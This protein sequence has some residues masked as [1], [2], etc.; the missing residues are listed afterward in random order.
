MPEPLLLLLTSTTVSTIT[1]GV[2]T[3]RYFW[4]ALRD[5]SWTEAVQPVL[6]LHAFRFVGLAFLI[7]GVVAPNLPVP[8]AVPSCGCSTCGRQ[9]I[10]CSLS[11]RA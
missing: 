6:G 11:T 2:V 7:P 8:R 9:P 3:V 4:P 1:W 10:C 5:R